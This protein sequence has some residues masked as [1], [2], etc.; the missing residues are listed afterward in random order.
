VKALSIRQPWI[1]LILQGRKRLEIRSWQT[2]H[3]GEIF[4][5]SAYNLDRPAM[6]LYP[7]PQP[8]T[9]AIVGT[10]ELVDVEELNEKR[11]RERAEF[12]LSKWSWDPD[13]CRYGFWLRG[14][15]RLREP[16]PCMG[17]SFLWEVEE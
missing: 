8:Q 15:Q 14:A 16:R 6:K 4:L 10:V 1:E 3:R 7:V 13:R 17:K 2:N 5:H 12:H 11:W 9:S